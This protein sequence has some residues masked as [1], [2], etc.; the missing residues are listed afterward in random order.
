MGVLFDRIQ[1]PK[2]H[3]IIG[4]AMEVHRELG[5]GFLKGVYQE[6]LEME[7]RDRGIPFQSQPRVA[8]SYKDRIRMSIRR[9]ACQSSIRD[10]VAASPTL[11]YLRALQLNDS[12]EG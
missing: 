10:V 4:A 12:N 6:A 5:S 7:F 1:D 3:A 2:T 11:R 9:P 8:I